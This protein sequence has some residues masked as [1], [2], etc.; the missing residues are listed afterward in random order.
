MGSQGM[1][2]FTLAQL[3]QLTGLS[4]QSLGQLTRKGVVVKIARDQYALSAIA[5]IIKHQHD[6]I[7]GLGQGVGVV[8]ER[9]EYLVEKTRMAKLERQRLEG[10]LIDKRLAELTLAHIWRA[11]RDLWRTLPVRVAPQ[12][13]G[14]E[15]QACF[16]ILLQHV[17]ETLET[18]SNA[19]IT[20]DGEE[21]DADEAPG[22]QSAA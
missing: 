21:E 6:Q 3:T 14:K 5:R 18:I 12:V 4:A 8:K 10:N 9:R 11:E 7:K 1:S 20:F 15:V 22:D 2:A 16:A 19:E 13:A 17:D